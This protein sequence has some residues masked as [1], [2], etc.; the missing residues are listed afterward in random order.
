MGRIEGISKGKQ[1]DSCPLTR[2]VKANRRIAI[3]QRSGTVNRSRFGPRLATA[4]YRAFAATLRAGCRLL[5]NRDP[6]RYTD[7]D[8]L[9]TVWVD[10]TRIERIS[11]RLTREYGSVVDGA[12]DED[13]DPIQEDRVFQ[14]LR[15]RYQDGV[16]WE[17]TLL[18]ESFRER[19]ESGDPT[20]WTYEQYLERFRSLDK[21]YESIKRDGYR[22][23]RSMFALD[24]EESLRR[25]NDSIHPY[26]N[27]VG[28]DIGREGTLLW[29]SGGRHRLFI[30][31]LLDISEIPVKVLSR[32]RKWQARRKRMRN[33]RGAEA[34]MDVEA[35]DQRESHPDLTDLVP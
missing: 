34:G 17:E 13:G 1:D 23:Q 30:A 2:Y 27:E 31:K 9:K 15:Q 11:N 32:H 28:I 5:H 20:V 6:K 4:H 19:I 7:A 10:P 22:S 18:F 16:P 3:E 25:N 24:A 8:P 26:L 14:S 21:V 12:W 33:E 29:R 35:L